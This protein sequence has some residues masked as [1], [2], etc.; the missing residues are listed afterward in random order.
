MGND[1]VFSF[2]KEWAKQKMQG[3]LIHACFPCSSDELSQNFARYIK[4]PVKTDSD[5]TSRYEIDI[6]IHPEAGDHDRM[7]TTRFSAAGVQEN[8]REF[9]YAA[10]FHTRLGLHAELDRDLGLKTAFSTIS[11]PGFESETLFA[12]EPDLSAIG[13]EAAW[14]AYAKG[15]GAAHVVAAELCRDTPHNPNAAKDKTGVALNEIVQC[16]RERFFRLMFGGLVTRIIMEAQ[17]R[18]LCHL[19]AQDYREVFSAGFR[20]A[21]LEAADKLMPR[22]AEERA[23]DEGRPLLAPLRPPPVV[24]NGGTPLLR[25]E[26]QGG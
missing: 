6:F 16:E 9:N 19:P 15:K 13:A 14:S 20:T 21:L 8:L 26:G 23:F 1:L 5:A 25:N 4:R 12:T 18:F 24:I 2:L 17:D 10:Q 3:K 22:S 7:N 11:T